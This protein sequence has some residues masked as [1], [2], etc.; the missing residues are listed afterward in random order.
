MVIADEV[1][2]NK[3]SGSAEL[4]SEAAAGTVAVLEWRAWEGFL[5]TH[6]LGRDAVRIETDPF[7]ELP[8]E[9]FDRICDSFTTVCFQINLS[10]R[11]RLPLRIHDL[12]NRFVKRGV[13]VVNGFVRDI[14]KSV[15]HAHLEAIGLTSLK[16]APGGAADEILFVKTDLNYG[17]ELERWLPAENI[18]T[19][20]FE[21]LISQEVGAYRYQ[22]VERRML[23]TDVWSD[24]AIV[25]ERYVTNSED[26]FYRVY[27]SG[28]QIIIVE[29]FA[30]RII[31]KLSGDPRDTNYVTDLE[32]LKSGT[33]DLELNAN[34]KR[35]VAT[36]VGNTPVEFGSI[37]IVH[38]GQD[39]HYIIDLN[40]TPYAGTR[41]HDPFLTNFLRMGIMD[42]TRRKTEIFLDSPLAKASAAVGLRRNRLDYTAN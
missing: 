24:P 33:D 17:G 21:H 26:S 18:A 32:H 31:K 9:Q 13:Y 12:T 35:I 11:G 7:S 39:N 36:F 20:G 5:L 28:K 6:V 15:L 27:F 4:L 3:P 29:A 2:A 23:Q 38:D 34:L 1:F 25:V 30:P 14:R 42:P 19:C 16:A 41:T 40:L 8:P 37:D 10:V 22:T